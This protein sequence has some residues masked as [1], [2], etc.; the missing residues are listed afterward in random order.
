MADEARLNELLDLV[1]QARAEGDS[2]TEQKAT[3]A[4]KRESGSPTRYGTGKSFDVAEDGS[5]VPSGSIWYTGAGVVPADSGLAQRE[6]KYGAPAGFD[7][8]IRQ[9]DKDRLA[10]IPA[11][12][13]SGVAQLAGMPATAL[14]NA[15]N[16]ASAG[17]GFAQSKITGAPPSP[18]FDP[19]NPSSIPL[20]GAFNERMLNSTP[21]G[22][23]TRPQNEND[24]MSR[25]LHAT[26]SGVPSG[27]VGGG[28]LK[29]SIAAG[30]AGGF[31]AG[32]SAEAGA[33]PATQAT[34]ALLAGH[35]AATLANRPPPQSAAFK[36]ANPVP[37]SAQL[38]DAADDLYRASEAEGVVIKPESTQRVVTMMQRVADK[39]NLGKLPPKLK[40]A[41][42]ILSARVTDGK[43]LTLSDADKVRQLIGD[44]FKSTDNADRRIARIVQNEYD[45]YLDNLKPADTLA[46]D[47]ARGVEL[48]GMARDTFRRRRNS[49]MLDQMERTAA[50]KGEGTYT[51][52]GIEHALRREFEKLATKDDKRHTLTPEQRAAVDRVVAPGKGANALRNIGKFD[53]ARGGMGMAL[54]GAFGGGA[55]AAIGG[56][57]GDAIAGA[58]A[59]PLIFGAAA[60]LA[61]R[62]STK[63]TQ[64]NV[65]K[66]REALVGRGL[67]NAAP[68]SA[69][70]TKP[71]GLLGNGVRTPAAIQADIRALDSY[72]T[73]LAALGPAGATARQSV[74]VELA[75]LRDEL[76]AFSAQGERP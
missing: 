17:A 74:E 28:P 22:N 38:K 65:A 76:G 44:A 18:F 14:T 54:G 50:R 49:E 15:S 10:S 67:L 70:A 29:P 34:L 59:G 68:V 48:L 71:Q 36:K 53:P 11:G 43:P 31:A 19:V 24:P 73:R 47:S 2:A 27:L 64:N 61:N 39:E 46:G 21:M 33:D 30:A 5:L 66:A 42:D 32:A 75:R 8:S 13:N 56:L 37:T 55:G 51:Q 6:K 69:T 62:G 20:T 3:A 72:V 1:E 60:N 41:S 7:F 63:I 23:V 58:A 40:E 57:T 52:A 16:L 9:E 4:Y 12:F 45:R 25:V 35:G 26:A